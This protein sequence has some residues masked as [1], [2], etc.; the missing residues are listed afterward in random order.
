MVNDSLHNS[1]P[2]SSGR[3]QK[4]WEFVWTCQRSPNQLD[5]ELIDEH[6]ARR[7]NQG[8]IGHFE[9]QLLA[10]ISQSNQKRTLH[11]SVTWSNTYNPLAFNL[12]RVALAL[13]LPE[14]PFGWVN[15]IAGADPGPFDHPAFRFF[16]NQPTYFP[17]ATTNRNTL[18]SEF[19]NQI[20]TETFSKSLSAAL[21]F[22]SASV[23]LHAVSAQQVRGLSVVQSQIL[24]VAFSVN[25]VTAVRQT[26]CDHRV[27]VDS[28]SFW[29]R[30][31][32]ENFCRSCFGEPEEW[33]IRC[34][35]HRKN[36]FSSVSGRKMFSS[37]SFRS[38]NRCIAFRWDD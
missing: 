29:F 20:A 7:T 13:A 37:S 25:N 32:K 1:W 33:G 3:L 22:G 6:I 11:E 35:K 14:R 30:C 31:T 5:R 17:T 16:A 28:P 21:I 27:F 8:C 24:F 10:S 23:L 15:P 38:P 26:K 2:S 36:H 4:G 12:N 9:G 18:R 34:E 19:N